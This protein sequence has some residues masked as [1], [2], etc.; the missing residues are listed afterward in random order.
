MLVGAALLVLGALVRFAPDL[1]SWFGN[2]PGDIRIESENS[3][4]FIPVTS[5]ILVSI[6]LTV[7]VN[8]VTSILR[9][10]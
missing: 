3:H 9:N 8:V 2:L 1:F 4:V 10:H 5:M 7:V 6:V